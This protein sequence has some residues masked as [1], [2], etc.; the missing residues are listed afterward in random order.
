M[1]TFTFMRNQN[2]LVKPISE[3]CEIV[4]IPFRSNL[5]PEIITKVMN[6]D[7][8]EILGIQEDGSW[9]MEI[10]ARKIDKPIYTK[11]DE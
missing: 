1:R 5:G 9:T 2:D 4:T 3:E 11:K 8:F 6:T 7:K 10:I